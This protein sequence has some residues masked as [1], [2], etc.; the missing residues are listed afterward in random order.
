MHILEYILDVFVIYDLKFD[1]FK[2]LA[3]IVVPIVSEE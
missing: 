2:C 1:P 3:V